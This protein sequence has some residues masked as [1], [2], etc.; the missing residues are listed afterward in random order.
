MIEYALFYN[1]FLIIEIWLRKYYIKYI[2][3]YN[4]KK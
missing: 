4:K 1:K 3:L 2:D